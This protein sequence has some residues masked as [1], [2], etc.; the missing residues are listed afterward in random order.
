MAIRVGTSSS[1]SM[2]RSNRYR[3]HIP[4]DDRWERSMAHPGMDVDQLRPSQ[5]A[6]EAALRYGEGM[7]AGARIA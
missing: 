5:S 7:V 1:T 4:P 2:D 6:S 3:M